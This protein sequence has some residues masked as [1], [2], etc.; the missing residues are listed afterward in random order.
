[1]VVAISTLRRAATAILVRNEVSNEATPAIVAFKGDERFLGEAAKSQYTRNITNTVVNLPLLLGATTAPEGS[2]FAF[3]DGKVVADFKL[4]ED[5]GPV[6]F[7]P[8]ALL[9][10][11]LARYG[12][13]RAVRETIANNFGEEVAA[14]GYEVTVAVPSYFD[15]AQKQAVADACG[16]AGLPLHAVIPAHVALTSQ[17]TCRHAATLVKFKTTTAE[18]PGDSHTVMFIGAPPSAHP[19]APRPLRLSGARLCLACGSD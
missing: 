17:Y 7:E 19:L 16:I 8:E 1:M 9:A 6:G 2:T 10:M 15:S 4:G 14:S 18:E 3:E 11:L 5:A 13:E 12:C